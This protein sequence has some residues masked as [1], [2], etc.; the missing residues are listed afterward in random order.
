[1]RN[2][3]L[4]TVKKQLLVI[5]SNANISDNINYQFFQET[6]KKLIKDKK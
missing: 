2:T 3:Q 6:C 4:K 1:M 5:N